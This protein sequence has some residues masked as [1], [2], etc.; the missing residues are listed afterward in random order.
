LRQRRLKNLDEKLASV[1][2]YM[3][4]TPEAMKGCWSEKLP[5]AAGK[6]LILELGCGKGQFISGMAQKR[7]DC[8]FIGF[9]GDKSVAYHAMQKVKLAEC[10]NVMIVPSYIHS[11]KEFFA[12]GELDGMFL[13][14]SDPW[15]KNRSEKRR[16]TYAG[17]LR[18]YADI[19]RSGGFIE[20]RTDNDDFF[21]YSIDQ[22]TS[23]EQLQIT[24]MLHDLHASVPEGSIVTTEYEDKFSSQGKNINFVQIKVL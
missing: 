4:E 16:L 13:N 15:P 11:M 2:E 9:E 5:G 7:P 23:V 6:P 20:F 3:I 21:Q 17:R 8:E 14:F 24:V 18:E 10:E 12:D 22:I 1:S 19:V